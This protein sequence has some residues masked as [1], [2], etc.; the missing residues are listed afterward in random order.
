MKDKCGCPMG[1]PLFFYILRYHVC[2]EVCVLRFL[3]GQVCVENVV[4]I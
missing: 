3:I 2:G 4:T 1:H